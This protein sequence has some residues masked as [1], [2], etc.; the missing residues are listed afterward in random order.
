MLGHFWT[1]DND[2]IVPLVSCFEFCKIRTI[3]FIQ[4]EADVAFATCYYSPSFASAEPSL[5][6]VLSWR[7]E[8]LSCW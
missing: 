5:A 1:S 2:Q 3:S 7:A 8:E 4:F 6:E